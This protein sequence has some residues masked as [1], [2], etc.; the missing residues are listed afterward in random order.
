MGHRNIFKFKQWDVIY[1]TAIFCV[2]TKN[3]AEV[4][5]IVELAQNIKMQ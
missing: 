3:A 2:Q 5:E 1:G 4:K